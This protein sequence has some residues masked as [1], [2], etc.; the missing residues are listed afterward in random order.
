[1]TIDPQDWAATLPTLYAQVWARLVRGVGDRH[2]AA[3]HPTLATVS[4]GGWPQV[5]TVVLRAA[6]PVAG[7]LEVHTDLRSAK[8]AELR[9]NPRAGLHVWDGGAHLQSRI[10]VTVAILTGPEVAAIWQRVPDPSR[11]SYGSQPAPGVPIVGALDYDKR[12]DAACFA[13][14]RCTVVAIEALHLGPQHRRARFE[15]GDGW[16]GQWLAP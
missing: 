3:R 7:V 6:D 16:V 11:Q 15:R 10:E 2:A 5:R 9:L 1:M 12:P 14:L 4:A 8:V 13:V